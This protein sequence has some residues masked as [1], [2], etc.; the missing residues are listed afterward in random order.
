MM[1]YANGNSFSFCCVPLHLSIS[2]FARS[3]K[4][5]KS[6][7]Y[8]STVNLQTIDLLIYLFIYLLFIHVNTFY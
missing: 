2:V 3:I 6:Q 1:I 4:P 5:E 8:F 7:Y